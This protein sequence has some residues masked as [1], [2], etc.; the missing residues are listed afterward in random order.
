MFKIT[1]QQRKLFSF[2]GAASEVYIGVC[3]KCGTEIEISAIKR[4]YAEFDA[5]IFIRCSKCGHDVGMYVAT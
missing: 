1:E 2:G 4:E 5:P 3:E